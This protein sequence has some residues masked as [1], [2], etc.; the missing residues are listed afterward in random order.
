MVYIVALTGGISSG[1][2]TVAK[3]FACYGVNIV[4]T[5]IIARQ[6]VKPGTDILVRITKHFG[7]K[8]LLENGALNR[9]MMREII[10]GQYDNRIWLN[11]LLHPL[12]YQETKHQLALATSPYVLWIVPL[13]VENNLQQEADRILVIDVNVQTQLARTVTR[14]GIS[15]QQ[16]QDILLAQASREQRLAIADDII[17]NNKG[18][19]E[20]RL[21]VYVLHIYYLRL[22]DSASECNSITCT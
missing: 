13:L 3:A 9:I 14:D 22:A 6:I 10:F 20:I 12:I 11:Q 7:K 2:S 16:A 15:H 8:V 21:A 5:D 4:D 19:L 1:K 18:S 17:N